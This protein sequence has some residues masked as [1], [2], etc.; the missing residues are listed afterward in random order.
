M[1]RGN[2]AVMTK[3]C[4]Q[5]LCARCHQRLTDST[6][7]LSCP[8]CRGADGLQRINFD[9]EVI[10]SIRYCM[11]FIEKCTLSLVKPYLI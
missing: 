7:R 11:K 6:G 1:S 4:F 3:C 2:K 8:F 9:I 10:M 5:V